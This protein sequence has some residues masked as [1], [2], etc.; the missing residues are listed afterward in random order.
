R[1]D[2]GITL[3]V[4]EA[5]RRRIVL[6]NVVVPIEHPHRAVGSD[7][8]RDRRRPFVAAGQQVEAIVRHERAALLV[9][10]ALSDEMAG[11]LGDEGN[12]VPIRWRKVSG[13]VDSMTGGGRETVVAIYL[14]DSCYGMNISV[15]GHASRT[16]AEPAAYR[17]EVAIGD[18]QIGG[19]LIVSRGVE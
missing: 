7:L 17:L 10:Q 3:A 8:R 4:L 6:H 1:C 18:R 15:V 9:E 5:G 14:P 12:T 2:V 11:R 19:M 13:R 16:L